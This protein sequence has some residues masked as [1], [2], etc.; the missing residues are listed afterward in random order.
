M[1]LCVSIYQHQC[2][3]VIHA[4]LNNLHWRIAK[5][6]TPV[7]NHPSGSIRAY[8]KTNIFTLVWGGVKLI[9]G[10][11]LW[12]MWRAT[13][14][15][16]VLKPQFLTMQHTNSSICYVGILKPLKIVVLPVTMKFWAKHIGSTI[17]CRIP[18]SMQL[19]VPAR[20]PT[21]VWPH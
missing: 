15:K 5:H 18:V 11:F 8:V 21:L 9:S 16:P 20:K 6:A 2:L 12:L 3:V 4:I 1:P 10:V 13:P 17:F 14:P 19:F 7:I